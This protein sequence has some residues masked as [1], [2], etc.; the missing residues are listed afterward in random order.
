MPLPSSSFCRPSI[1]GTDF[2]IGPH[3]EYK[4]LLR[5]EGALQ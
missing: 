5:T 3:K 1:P 4:I 2:K